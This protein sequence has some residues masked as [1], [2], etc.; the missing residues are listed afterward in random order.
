[1][2]KWVKKN[3][4]LRV[5]TKLEKEKIVKRGKKQKKEGAEYD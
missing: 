4:R 1:M 5:Q 3:P 2:K